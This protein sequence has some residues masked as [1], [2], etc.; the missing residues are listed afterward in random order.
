MK[1]QIK[2]F[3]TYTLLLVSYFAYSQ[4]NSMIDLWQI[5]KVE[6]GEDNMTPV[7]K[8]TRINANGT[9]QSGNGWLQNSSGTWNYE[10]KTNTYSAV[11]QLDIRDEFGGFTV[12]FQNDLM[13]WEREEEG[14]SVKVILER[15]KELPMSPADYLEGM[16]KLSE[17]SK[18]EEVISIN[19]AGEDKAKLFIRWDR[20]FL[21]F[22]PDGNKSSG[23]WHIHGHKS[24]ITLLPHQEN[25]LAESW[26]IQ[27][28]EKELIMTGLSDSNK[29]VQ[30]NYIRQYSF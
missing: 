4:E 9:Y 6:V 23:Y 3:L 19:S 16:W 14:M 17:I 5:K 21:G 22:S 29:G 30:R 2:Q 7:A 8:W 18:N 10:K 1:N 27:V 25:G 20:I 24:E 28:N 12:S 13:I 26:K 15:I 11:D